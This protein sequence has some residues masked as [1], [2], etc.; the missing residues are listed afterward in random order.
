MTTQ[1]RAAALRFDEDR[2]RRDE[3]GFEHF[4]DSAN[5]QVVVWSV[6]HLIVQAGRKVS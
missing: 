4:I 1:E 2:Q 5:G 6:L 3:I